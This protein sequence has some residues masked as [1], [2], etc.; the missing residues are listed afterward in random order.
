MSQCSVRITAISHDN[1]HSTGGGGKFR[2]SGHLSS[3]VNNNHVQHA[4]I[5]NSFNY[6]LSITFYK[7]LTFFLCRKS[8]P[9]ISHSSCTRSSWPYR[10]ASRTAVQPSWGKGAMV[11]CDTTNRRGEVEC[12]TKYLESQGLLPNLSIWHWQSTAFVWDVDYFYYTRL[13]I[14]IPKSSTHTEQTHKHTICCFLNT[15]TNYY[16]EML[17][18]NAQRHNKGTHRVRWVLFTSLI[19]QNYFNYH[20]YKMR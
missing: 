15:T 8:A 17:M 6:S 3:Y 9:K 2:P 20:K 11:D 1:A 19:S 13:T 7:V 16:L 12:G 10:A 5:H 4:Y 14:S 18:S